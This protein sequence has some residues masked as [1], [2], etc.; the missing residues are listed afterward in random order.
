MDLLGVTTYIV[1]GDE[2]NIKLTRPLDRLLAA[3]ILRDRRERDENR[4]GL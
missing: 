2:E 1:E 4:P 3:A